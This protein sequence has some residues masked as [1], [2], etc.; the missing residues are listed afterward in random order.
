MIA[1]PPLVPAWQPLPFAPP[2][3]NTSEA[4]ART[5]RQPPARER[6]ALATLAHELRGPL[7]SLR[8]SAA[9]QNSSAPVP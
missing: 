5:R 6:S 2:L 7:H 4:P 9:G 1:S 3:P 8:A